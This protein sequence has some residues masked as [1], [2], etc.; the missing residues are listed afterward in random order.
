MLNGTAR[1]VL[2]AVISACMVEG[3]DVEGASRAQSAPD[4]EW[5][6]TRNGV[7]AVDAATGKIRAEVPLPEWLWAKEGYAC[8]PVVARGPQGEAVITSNVTTTLWRVDPRTFEVT[9]H[10]LAGVEDRGIEFGFSALAYSAEQGA[11]FAVGT[12]PGSMWRV[13]PNLRGAQKIAVSE[14]IAAGCG[15]APRVMAQKPS[16]VVSLCIGGTTVNLAADQRT[17][18][19]NGRPC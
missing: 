14:P 17:G 5:T 10:E 19:V 13:D 1:K 18:Y 12:V 15:Q 6:L 9:V 3:C 4:I 16:R 7:T 8:A 11:Y 2:S